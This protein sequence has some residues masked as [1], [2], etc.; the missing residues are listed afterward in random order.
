MPN[1][2]SGSHPLLSVVV[3]VYDEE[4]VLP[5]FHRRLTAVLD[6]VDGTCEVVNP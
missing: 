6:G 3:L 1:E 2:S 5:A 4:S